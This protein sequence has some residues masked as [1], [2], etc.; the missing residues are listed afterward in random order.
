ME[1]HYSTGAVSQM[2]GVTRAT[3]AA[4]VAHG[5]LRAHRVGE[6][7]RYMIPESA[8]CEAIGPKTGRTHTRPETCGAQSL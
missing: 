6:R 5:K 7:G 1:K 3:V 8:L 2:V 4:W